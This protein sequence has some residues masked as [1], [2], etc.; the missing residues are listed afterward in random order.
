MRFK[1]RLPDLSTSKGRLQLALYAG[2]VAIGGLFFVASVPTVAS[3]STFCGVAC[4]SQN[5][6]WQ[7]WKESAHSQI[8]CYSCHIDISYKHLAQEKLIA[9]P[10]G[11][12]GEVFGLYEKPINADSHY[13]QKIPVERCERCHANENRE[14]SFSEGIIMDHDAHQ[15]AGIACAVCHNRVAHQGAEKFEPL[16]SAWPETKEAAR[17]A[18]QEEFAYKNF[19]KMKDGCFRCHSG[20]PESRD[21]KT[22]ELIKNGRR[23]PQA[24]TACHTG[25]F[26]LPR[27]HTSGTW[28]SEHGEAAREN[29]GDC[30]DC[31]AAGADYDNNGKDWCT[32][33]HA[34]EQADRFKRQPAPQPAPPPEPALE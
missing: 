33:C 34:D 24:C 11:I 8:T 3:N 18:G 20:S 14:F 17:K 7:S 13:S 21:P 10:V 16:K 30:F 29:F 4:H 32:L 26:D 9:G 5:P 23:A 22:L 27:G 31:H 25:D 15:G 12:I 28:R 19:M 1:P 6:Q 2:A